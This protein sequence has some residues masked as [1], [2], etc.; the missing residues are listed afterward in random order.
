[1][2]R[3]VS[4][5]VRLLWLFLGVALAVLIPL[6]LWTFAAARQGLA[7]LTG[8]QLDELVRSRAEDLEGLF[9]QDAERAALIASRTQMRLLT[10]QLGAG[11]GGPAEA[12]ALAGILGDAAASAASIQHL[13]IFS[14]A[15]QVLASTRPLEPD[16]WPAWTEPGVRG[17]NLHPAKGDTYQLVLPLKSARPGSLAEIGRLAVEIPLDRMVHLLADPSGLGEQGRLILSA[18]PGRP[19]SR[20]YT[21]QVQV[22][23]PGVTA[24]LTA[25][26]PV[27][28]LAKPVLELVL[29]ILA[30]GVF[31]SAAAALFL[32]H[33]LGHTV[34]PVEERFEQS[35][36]QSR[37]FVWEVDGA[38]FLTYVSR[39]LEPLLGWAPDQL[40]G[41]KLFTDLLDP[42]EVPGQRLQAQALLERG[43]AL[44]NWEA[45]FQAA[46]G[47]RL[48][49]STSGLAIRDGQG[50]LTGYRG[51]SVDVSQ[52]KATEAQALE[53]QK[54]KAVGQLAA[55]L[56]HDLN[57]QLTGILGL[58][59][60]LSL[61][62]PDAQSRQRL[63]GIRS[64]VE[65][66]RTLIRKLLAF[67]RQGRYELCDLELRSLAE[68]AATLVEHTKDRRIVLERRYACAEAW[69][70]A[71]PGQLEN[72]VLNLALNA[73]D[74]MPEGGTL[75]FSLD[76]LV[77]AES[78]PAPPGLSLKPGS[79][80]VF[81]VK[82]T[83][84]GMSPAVRAR[85]FEP[86]FST[87]EPNRGNGLGLASV[88]GTVKGLGGELQ[89]ETAPG[90][91][92]CFRLFLPEQP[93]P[94][95]GTAPTPEPRPSEAPS[96]SPDSQAP[97]V[98][99]IDDEPWITQVLNEYL[100]ASGF[101][102]QVWN[103]PA[104]AL[105]DLQVPGKLE[106]LDALLLDLM[107]PGLSGVQV[108]SQLRRLRPG[109]K[110]LLMSGYSQETQAQSL[111]DQGA[112]GFL[113]K[114]FD[115]KTLTATLRGL[116]KA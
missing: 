62:P 111:L 10:E 27:E 25:A 33:Q 6:L 59:E 45:P 14:T 110:V 18:E 24:W 19:Q 109:L 92:S 114:P 82:D 26:K 52:R 98:A 3:P 79:Y 68:E 66:S 50:R 95:A 80:A 76:R 91:G 55:G 28:D 43:E 104:Q 34:T 107:M 87:K 105:K 21:R 32:H 106:A 84:V 31:L 75:T 64:C 48:W 11:Q 102:V 35:A 85:L 29:S 112:A 46:S 9:V 41:Q 38:G 5:R 20:D 113:Q 7:E 89:V 12:R 37:S 42:G 49:F 23:L 70:R 53:S 67:S 44:H 57:N 71:D 81:A 1:M 36:L 73:C 4:L 72:A 13:A 63:D 101:R 77:L 58:T 2:K 17:L 88:Y 94:G 54:L 97:Q 115:L 99:V 116:A 93:R 78:E 8:D 22:Q 103:D 83:G 40:L 15:G 39:S 47:E 69:V 74:A 51:S 96:P 86:F 108:F 90:Q 30:L 16:A 56:A 61:N 60:L 100:G 65:H